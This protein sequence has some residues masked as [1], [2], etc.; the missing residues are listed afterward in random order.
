MNLFRTRGQVK[1]KVF[2]VN[3]T[4]M[5]SQASFNQNFDEM[6]SLPYW[7][8]DTETTGL[9]HIHDK[10]ILLQIGNKHK[11]FLID[12]RIV[13]VSRLKEK[14]EDNKFRKYLQNAVFDYKMMKSSLNI[15]MEFMQDGEIAERLLTCGLQKFGFGM[16]ALCLKYL[17]V[18]IDK[19]MQKSF[20]GHQGEFSHD[21]KRYAALDCVYPDNYLPIQLK[22]LH[23]A[24]MDTVFDI[25]CASIP[26]FG[27][28]EYYGLLLDR[29]AWQQNLAEEKI[30]SNKARALF[31][32]KAT[33]FVGTDLFGEPD[34]NPGSPDQVLKMFIQ[35]FSRELLLDPDNK[36]KDDKPKIGTGK[37]V[38]ENL[39][40]TE[41]SEMISALISFREHEKK[42]GTY[43]DTYTDHIDKKTGRFHLSMS[44]LGTE[45]GRP[46]GRKPNMLN[47]PRDGRYRTPWIAGPGRKILTNDYGACELRIMA[48]MSK[49]PVMCKGFNEGL[50][51]HTYTASQF[52]KEKEPIL[53][54]LIIG[55]EPGKAK[56]GAII[57]DNYGKQQENPLY[58]KLVPYENVRK[59]QR[60]VAKTIN[61]G[62]AYGM[63]PGKLGNT[64]KIETKESK[65][66]IFQFN[67]TFE[68]LVA[69]LKKQQE[70]G[71][72]RGYSETYL[73]RRRY[74]RKPVFPDWDP[75]WDMINFDHGNP[76]DEDM[77]KPL[78][79]Y[80]SRMAMIKREAG[81][82]PIQGGNAD[83][84]KIAMYEMRKY[85]KA[86]ELEHNN[87][88]YLAHVALQVYDELVLD[89]P[90]HLAK[91]FASVMDDVM[92]K[93]GERV[94]KHVPVETDCAIADTWV[95]E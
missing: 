66:Y 50:D 74:F 73:G 2:E 75:D 68:V 52:V 62:L 9:N 44:Q 82:S 93:A 55:K 67:T 85:V 7:V 38:L 40:N 6:M 28:M 14:F 79:K 11:Q 48:S 91:H 12:T 1:Q 71:L 49:D 41:H 43:G 34:I 53:K 57:L 78:K 45:T 70:I 17:K 76:F 4:F 94:I 81:N 27:D 19:F 54:E 95:K 25:E 31:M 29:D 5:G 63:G 23:K 83:I 8:T 92:K 32:E 61:F 51:Y 86:Y 58:G 88:E 69:W 20:I 36:D 77:P 22:L 16:E 13:D 89:C 80:H 65:E 87:G 59:P 72:E 15:T 37:R 21:Q 90:E 26:A 64:L 84:T 35:I 47:I 18:K 60:T 30:A 33:Q 3:Y 10:V 42:I 24:G 39:L 46:A 56:F